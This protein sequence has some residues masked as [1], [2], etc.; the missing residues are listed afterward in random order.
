VSHILRNRTTNPSTGV[1][2]DRWFHYDQV[3]SV[4]SESD[5]SG[6]PAQTHHQ[7]AFGNTQAAWQTGLWGGDRAGWH[8][9]TKELD[10]DTGLVYMYQRWYAPETGT[11]IS[12]DSI[13][14]VLVHGQ[15]LRSVLSFAPHYFSPYAFTMSS[16]TRWMDP[17][18]EFAQVLFG[19]AAGCL[20]NG[21]VTALITDGDKKAMGCACLGG[22]I[23]G[24]LTSLF[25]GMG[26]RAGCLTQVA[27]SMAARLCSCGGKAFSDFDSFIGTL[28]SALFAC[29][30]GA[31][32]AKSDETYSDKVRTLVAGTVPQIL[33]S[34]TS[35]ISDD[36][37]GVKCCK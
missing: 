11:F 21:L 8:H 7:D 19:T 13:T 5:A 32:S 37:K 30:G 23:A 34:A 9:N 29:I 12:R 20:V 18:G 3:G 27:G 33:G 2:T 36:F 14:E 22:A 35:S 28:A 24:A 16:P 31:A 6:A 17:T 26:M 25:P 1:A 10:G 15:P 4:L